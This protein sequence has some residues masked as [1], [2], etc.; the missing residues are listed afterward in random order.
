MRAF[1]AL[2][3]GLALVASAG[4]AEK[5]PVL[6]W[7]GQSFFSLES[8]K[9]TKVVFD[10]HT[11]E[12]YGRPMPKADMILISH[13]HNDHTQIGAVANPRE[14]KIVHGLQRDGKKTDW[15]LVDEKL[16]DVKVRSVGSYH[17]NMKG[18]ERGKNTIFIVEVD[19]QRIVHLG[20]LGHKLT[21]E[22][23]RRIGPVDVLMIPVGG[24]YTLNGAEAKEVV[25]QI[26][27]KKYIVPMH[28]GTEVFDELLPVTEFLEDQ[29]NVKR[30]AGNR[31]A[32]EPD[33]DPKE[34]TI[35]LLKWK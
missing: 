14:A 5:G 11:I 6:H 12:V 2:I 16:K 24:I 3:L 34:P 23:V 17:D 7:H 15:R 13:L 29:K 8:S 25:A 1:S 9:G 10:P 18:L 21:P 30:Y 35:V 20:D 31:L 27:P 32:I 33:S 22:Q 26:K 28:H 4:A 19:G